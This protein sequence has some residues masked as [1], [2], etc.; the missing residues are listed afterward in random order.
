MLMEC[1]SC[2]KPFHTSLTSPQIFC[3]IG[4]QL[5]KDPLETE[6]IDLKKYRSRPARTARIKNE[7]RIR[8][9]VS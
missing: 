3:S 8:R 5:L 2:G 4:C 9:K 6:T 1:T 7:K